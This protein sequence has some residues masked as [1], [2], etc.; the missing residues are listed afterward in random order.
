[1]FEKIKAWYAAHTE[2]SHAIFVAGTAAVAAYNGY[3]PFHDLVQ[4]AYSHVPV[5]VKV[6]VATGSWGYT[7]YHSGRK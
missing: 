6:L 5:S 1:M 2:I 4:Q 7:W 3:P